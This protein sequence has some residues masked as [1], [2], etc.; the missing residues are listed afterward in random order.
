MVVTPSLV[1]PNT[2]WTDGGSRSSF[3][4]RGVAPGYCVVVGF[5]LRCCFMW[6]VSIVYFEPLFSFPNKSAY[7][8]L[9]FLP[10]AFVYCKQAVALVLFSKHRHSCCAVCLLYVEALC[11][12]TARCSVGGSNGGKTKERNGSG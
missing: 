2:G 11:S 10:W 8:N 9:T 12:F 1:S 6:G 7:L 3:S 5:V 4:I